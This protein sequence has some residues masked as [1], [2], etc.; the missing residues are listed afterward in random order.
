MKPNKNRKQKAIT[1]ESNPQALKH[2][3][4]KDL[5][6]RMSTAIKKIYPEFDQRHFLS[7]IQELETLELKPRIQF[8]RQE[9]QKQLPQNYHQALQI[10]L[11]S[12][13]SG[14]LKGFDLWPYTDFVQSY[15]IDE[16]KVSLDA[17]KE[18]TQLFTAEFAVRPFLKRYP[19]ETLEYLRHCALHESVDIRRWASEG[20]RPRL[21]WGERL[22]EFVRDPSPALEILE[23]L[24][25]DSELYVRK[26]VS[27]H[28]N[29]I[30][31]DHPKKV[32]EL[33][34]RWKQTAGHEHASKIDWIIRHSLRTLIKAGHPGALKLIGV[35][36]QPQIRFSGF[37]IDRKNYKIN[38][39]IEFE[40]KVRSTS[41]RSQKLVVDYI[42]HYRKANQQ[43]TPKVFKFKT[44][45]LPPKGELILS[46]SHTLKK[47]TTR[48]HYTGIHFLEIQVNGRILGRLEWNLVAV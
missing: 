27:N 48:K 11:K 35:S 9:L 33:L 17:L 16:L 2:L 45:H 1:P 13:Q 4:G 30:A 38:E 24:K 40:F 44:I 23:C 20:T 10:L 8:L 28:L 6:Q 21:P 39:R 37:K 47:V 12:T 3:V 41:S 32:I 14:T 19:S 22:H 18:L 34:A 31:K 25:F 42:V 36:N 46:K 43:A 7:L 29:D 5:L 26:S 15:G